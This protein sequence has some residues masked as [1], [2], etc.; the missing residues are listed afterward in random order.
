MQILLVS[1][2][3]F[4]TVVDLSSLDQGK[5]ENINI[6]YF[7]RNTLAIAGTLSLISYHL[8]PSIEYMR[9]PRDANH[10]STGGKSSRLIAVLDIILR[11]GSKI[12]LQIRLHSY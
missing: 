6:I 11:N 1:T 12:S 4:L 8:L 5:K 9:R 10:Q 7:E 2:Q 3:T